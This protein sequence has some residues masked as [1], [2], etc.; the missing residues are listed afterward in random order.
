MDTGKRA[1]RS[2][3]KG[4]PEEESRRGARNGQS[5][6]FQ[7]RQGGEVEQTLWRRPGYRLQAPAAGAHTR[8][9]CAVH[10]I[11]PLTLAL[12]SQVQQAPPQ[13]MDDML[14]ELE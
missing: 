11:D 13:D 10:S 9:V 2:R 7:G 5:A 1:G 6:V 8:A 12:H 14:D 4:T 3:G